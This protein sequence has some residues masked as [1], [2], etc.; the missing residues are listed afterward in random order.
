MRVLYI[1]TIGETMDFF[2]PLIQELVRK[3]NVVDIA[4]NEKK[5]PVSNFFRN[6][7]CKIYEISTSRSPLNYGNIKA[8]KQVRN[9]AINYDIV[10]CHTPIA[11]AITRI[12]CKKIRK[13][14]GLKVVYTAHGFHFYKG[15]PI[16]NWLLYYPIEKWCSKMT[17]A[18]ITINE[19]DF[20]FAILNMKANNVFF[21]PG[22]GI[23]VKAIS[24]T[25]VNKEQKRAELGIPNDAFMIM[26]IG[27]LNKNKNHRVVIKAIARI[28]NQSVYYVIAGSGPNYNKLKKFASSLGVNLVL[29]GYRKDIYELLKIADL[30]IHPSFREGLPVSV[31]ECVASGTNCICSNIRGC[32]DIINCE[33]LFEPNDDYTLAKKIEE[34]VNGQNI[35]TCNSKNILYFDVEMVNKEMISIYENVL[36]N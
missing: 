29:L 7:G 1:T 36:K 20:R 5:A 32:K 25:V 34:C 9:I 8:V 11:G 16:R 2:K 10:H 24:D 27:E 19:E 23:N 13:K 26:S 15:A 33:N 17:D 3:G 28:K 31:L 30:F 21:V 6:C 22:V 4:T 12:A 14:T 35:P 18:L